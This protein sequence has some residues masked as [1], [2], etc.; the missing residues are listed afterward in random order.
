MEE[1]EREAN[2]IVDESTVEETVKNTL[3]NKFVGKYGSDIDT[4][5]NI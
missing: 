1:E 4:S 5:N 2:I 3:F